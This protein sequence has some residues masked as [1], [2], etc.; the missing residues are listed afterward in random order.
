MYLDNYMVYPYQFDDF[1][2]YQSPRPPRPPQTG[3]Q[4]TPP[5]AQI[6][7]RHQYLRSLSQ[8]QLQE[9]VQKVRRGE[10]IYFPGEHGPYHR[11]LPDP[12]VLFGCN[13]K[14]ANILVGAPGRLVPIVINIQRMFQGGFGE[15]YAEGFLDPEGDGFGPF[16]GVTYPETMMQV[17]IPP[18][19]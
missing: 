14:W 8:P 19:L 5:P 16:F 3:R 13:G 4:P 10:P 12:S 11:S 9:I 1:G 15:Y 18:C 2:R 6:V 17:F 7:N